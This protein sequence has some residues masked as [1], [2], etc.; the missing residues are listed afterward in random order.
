MMSVHAAQPAQVVV[1]VTG[2]DAVKAM[3]P[4][5]E[6][7]VIGIDVLNVDGALDMNAC[8]EVDGVVANAGVLRKIAVGWIVITDEQ[9]ILGQDRL[10]C[11]A[12]LGF[13]HLPGSRDPVQGLP[14]AVSG[15]QN[16]DQFAG[17]ARFARLAAATPGRAIQLATA[18]ARL[19]DIGLV[20]LGD[21]LQ[22]C[23][24]VCLEAAEKAMAP[25]QRGV[26]MHAQ[27]GRRRAKWLGRGQ[28]T[29]K[30]EPFV[31]CGG[32]I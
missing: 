24:A 12:Q 29:A 30:T 3:K 11:A 32:L 15:H 23:R 13:A 28:R 20:G 5:F 21:A 4:W 27:R 17:Q 2:G 26:A 31:L 10:Q 7:V 16:A 18:L 1:Q 14:G 8:A 19:Q 9:R 25:A 6:A 22:R